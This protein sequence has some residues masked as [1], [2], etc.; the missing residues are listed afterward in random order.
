[1]E[2]VCRGFIL[3]TIPYGDNA[4]V[5]KVLTDTAGAVSFMVSGAKRKGKT[6]KAGLFSP[7]SHVSISFVKKENRDMFGTRKVSM[8]KI[9]PTLHT[10]VRKPPV[11]VYMAEALYKAISERH[12]EDGFYFF[13][14]EQMKLLDQLQNLNHFPQQFLTGLIRLFGFSPQG[15][16]SPQTPEFYLDEGGFLPLNSGN[17]HFCVS[18]DS[19]KHLSDLFSGN[20][21][22]M[23]YNRET[24][25][26]VR[27]KLED[28]L[29]LHLDGR[30]T[31]VSGEVLEMIFEE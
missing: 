28:Y 22:Q 17:P 3:R 29:K 4:L 1:M 9:Y 31:L 5:T 10:D 25:R 21:S 8:H 6:S 11:S 12:P 13:A 18:G 26:N 2:E 24:R 14:E 7:M 19:A 27:R 30:F 23:S 20:E 16:Y 15:K